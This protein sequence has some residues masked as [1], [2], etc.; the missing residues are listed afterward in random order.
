MVAPL[1]G[2]LLL[3]SGVEAAQQ[4][5][6]ISAPREIAELDLARMRGEPVRLAWSPDEKQIYLQ[7]ERDDPVAACGIARP[8]VLDVGRWSRR[9]T[10]STG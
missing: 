4:A 6:T 10:G 7:T 3:A 1:L 5:P 8:V 9:V 2:L